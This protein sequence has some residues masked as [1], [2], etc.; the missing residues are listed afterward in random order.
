VLSKNGLE[1]RTFPFRVGRAS[2]NESD[3]PLDINDLGLADEEPYTVSRT[4]FSIDQLGGKVVI[5]DR[6][7]YLGT[8][9]NGHVVGGQ[10]RE[11]EIELELGKNEVIVGR[12][13]SPYRFE[14]I[15]EKSG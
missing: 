5:Q 1:I 2:E 4:H 13:R 14:V 6:G 11:G 7:S 9:V 8:M 15:V 12:Q 3:D 10:R